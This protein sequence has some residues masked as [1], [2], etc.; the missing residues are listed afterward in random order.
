[1]QYFVPRSQLDLEKEALE[2][3]NSDD[4]LSQDLRDE[5]AARDREHVKLAQSRNQTLNEIQQRHD[6]ALD[7][8]AHEIE[9]EQPFGGAKPQ[10]PASRRM[11]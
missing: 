11:L 6:Q 9:E 10:A 1:M 3:L 2:Q 7:R 4:D 5:L 8:V